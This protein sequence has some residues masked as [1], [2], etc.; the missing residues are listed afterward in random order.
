MINVFFIVFWVFFVVFSDSLQAIYYQDED[1]PVEKLQY[2]DS[3]GVPSLLKHRGGAITET[4][5]GSMQTINPSG[6]QKIPRFRLLAAESLR[7]NLQ[8]WASANDYRLVWQLPYDFNI[9]YE[10]TIDESD[11]LRAIVFVL[12]SYKNEGVMKG[13]QAHIYDNRVIRISK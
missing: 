11:L 2:I 5:S 8:R 7:E 4:S 12:N 1:Y 3:S 6:A 10:A 13:V 9:D